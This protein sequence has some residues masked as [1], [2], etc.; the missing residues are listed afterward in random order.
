MVERPGSP[1]EPATEPFPILASPAKGRVGSDELSAFGS[2]TLCTYLG[3][4][5][6]RGLNLPPQIGILQCP[7]LN[8]AARR[9]ASPA[10]PNP[11]HPRAYLTAGR[12]CSEVLAQLTRRGVKIPNTWKCPLSQPPL[13]PPGHNSLSLNYLEL[14]CSVW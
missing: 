2:M 6:S 10:Q 8:R 9:K 13:P 5:K 12:S 1:P 11:A 4:R 14:H 7:S 3:K